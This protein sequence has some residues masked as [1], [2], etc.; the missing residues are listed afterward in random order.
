MQENKNL[1]TNKKENLNEVE[2]NGTK[3]YCPENEEHYYSSKNTEDG[4]CPVC[5]KKLKKSFVF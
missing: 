5:H 3:Y 2:S 1:E 4:L